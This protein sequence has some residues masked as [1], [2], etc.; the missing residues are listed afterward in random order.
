M[1]PVNSMHLLHHDGD[2]VAHVT[3]T[4]PGGQGARGAPPEWFA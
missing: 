4:A 2:T 1:L 3:G